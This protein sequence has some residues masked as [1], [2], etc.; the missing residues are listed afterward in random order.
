MNSDGGVSVGTNTCVQNW[1]R[2]PADCENISR[3]LI[4]LDERKYLTYPAGVTEV[5]ILADSETRVA[6]E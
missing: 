3:E 1:I 5:P 6:P 4:L 2:K